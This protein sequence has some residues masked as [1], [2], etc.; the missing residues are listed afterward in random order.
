MPIK[1][2]TS[3]VT[4]RLGSAEVDAAYLG[5]VA[6]YTGLHPEAKA[7]EEAVIANSGTVSSTTLAAVSDF[8]KSIDAAGIRDRF[9]RLNLFAG[10]GLNAA[11]VP[12]YRGPSRTGTQGGLTTDSNNGPF[13][14]GDYSET[15]GL[16]SNGSTKHLRIGTLQSVYQGVPATGHMSVW[17]LGRNADD[18]RAMGIFDLTLQSGQPYPM[19]YG[20]GHGSSSQ[21]EFGRASILPSTPPTTSTLLTVNRS[22][23]NAQQY[24]TNT[25]QVSTASEE[26]INRDIPDASISVWGQSYYNWNNNT[27]SHGYEAPAQTFSSYSC[28]QS[29][30]AAQV[31]SY[32][33]ALVAFRT[34]MGRT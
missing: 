3:D 26:S 33:N 9:Y 25:T 31:T 15:A 21:Q 32:Y 13:V 17:T 7:W 20:V 28:G 2:G 5:S 24:Y 6:T 11:L 18:K 8:C 19:Y 16:T 30:S 27:F 34:A 1:L 29:M 23:A 12:L 4:L 10:T 14:S 22:A